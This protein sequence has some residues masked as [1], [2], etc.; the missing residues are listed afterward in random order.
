MNAIT[1]AFGLVAVG[2]LAGMLCLACGAPALG[3]AVVVTAVFVGV[4]L[5]CLSFA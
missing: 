2:L 1:K 4:G 3:F 5:A